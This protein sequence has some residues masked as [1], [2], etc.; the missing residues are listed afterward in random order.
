[1]NTVI[2][3]GAMKLI[4]LPVLN[5]PPTLDSHSTNHWENNIESVDQE[6]DDSEAAFSTSV[7]RAR[8]SIAV[9][10]FARDSMAV[11]L[12]VL[13]EDDED[14]EG[15]DDMDPGRVEHDQQ[16]QSLQQLSPKTR[17]KERNTEFT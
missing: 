16:K 14:S 9:G 8:D 6:D 4:T 12:R 3:G 2:A 1:M 13:T 10:R 5:D 15:S 7:R 11:G 17:T